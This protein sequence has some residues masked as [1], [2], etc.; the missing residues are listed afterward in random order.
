MLFQ[1]VCVCVHSC[2][3]GWGGRLKKKKK[4]RPGI[5]DRCLPLTFSYIDI[6]IHTHTFKT[7]FL[8]VTLAILEFTPQPFI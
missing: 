5:D 8:R 1:C 4:E 7:G 6:D 3:H 2:A